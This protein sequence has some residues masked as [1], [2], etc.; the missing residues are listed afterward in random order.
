MLHLTAGRTD[1]AQF[2]FETTLKQCGQVLPALLGVAA[3]RYRR[4]DYRGALEYYTR[5]ISLF[6]D[7][8]G[9]AA[10]VGFGLACYRLG[11]VDRAKAAFKRAHAMDPKNAEAMVGLAVLDLASLDETAPDYRS[12]TE[13]AIRLLST[14]NLVDHSNAMVQNHL[15]DHYFWKWTP[16]PGTISVEAGSSVVKSSQPMNLDAGECLLRTHNHLI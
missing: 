10:R 6:P 9:S 12:R 4:E 16:V 7:R 15:A 2:F 14:A 1:Q 5:A 8:S 11:Q 13:D 3:V